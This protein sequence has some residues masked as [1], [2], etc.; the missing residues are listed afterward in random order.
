MFH[1][2]VKVF[3]RTDNTYNVISEGKYYTYAD[4]IETMKELK[5]LYP[6]P[7]GY[8]VKLYEIKTIEL[9]YDEWEM[10]KG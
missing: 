7:M 2:E 9:D 4:A 8:K 3:E 6:E 1:Y 10:N 5:P